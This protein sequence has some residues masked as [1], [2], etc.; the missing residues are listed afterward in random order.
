MSEESSWKDNLPDGIKD[1]PYFKNAES[2]EQVL[3][4]LTNAA[5]WQGNSIRLPGQDAGDSDFADFHSRLMEKVPGLMPTPN[6]EDA[7]AMNPVWARLGKPD[8]ADGYQVPEGLVMDVSAL[9]AHA[10]NANMT[11]KQFGELIG[12][13]NEE[14]STASETMRNQLES[15]Y[16]TLKTEWGAAYQQN[17]EL[18]GKLLAGAPEAVQQAYKDGTLPT[19]QLRWLNSISGL[20][21]EGAEVVGQEPSA[22]SIPTP[23]QATHDLAE[24][25]RRLFGMTPADPEYALLNQRRMKLIGLTMGLKELPPMAVI[26]S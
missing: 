25:E 10:H 3:A 20:G 26:E 21:D 4:D 13:L 12:R 14:Q 19:D 1:A 18:V 11:Q 5:Q 7:E 8:T 17:M 9:K 6:T 22:A 23:E 16:T 15:D 24:C 2:P